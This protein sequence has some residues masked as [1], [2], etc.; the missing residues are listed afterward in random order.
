MATYRSQTTSVFNTGG[1]GTVALPTGSIAG[2]LVVAQ[3][4]VFDA[5]SNAVTVTGW[6]FVRS[7]NCPVGGNILQTLIYKKILVAADITAGTMSVTVPTS[8]FTDF[9]L[10]CYTVSGEDVIGTGSGN[11][12]TST[13]CQATG[14][15]AV[16]G[17]ILDIYSTYDIATTTGPTGMTVRVNGYDAGSL[18]IYEEAVSAGATGTRTATLAASS[19]WTAALIQIG[20]SVAYAGRAS[21]ARA[22]AE[23]LAGTTNHAGRNLAGKSGAVSYVAYA[24]RQ[25]T[26]TLDF[27]TKPEQV[28]TVRVPQS[29]IAASQP[30]EAFMQ[31]DATADHNAFEHL[32]VPMKFVCSDVTASGG[33]SITAVS[34][35]PLT[36]KFTVRYV[37]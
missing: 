24:E 36:G 10:T 6:D 20:Q 14:I 12:G 3:I 21:E 17:T 31:G 1:T 4:V 23:S 8:R 11:S 7:D 2:D 37:W 30:V 33:F 34:P 29:T 18:N 32:V 35:W 28:A 16:A 13:S 25:G 26:A 22:G 27:G 19:N 5:H 15:T 9:A